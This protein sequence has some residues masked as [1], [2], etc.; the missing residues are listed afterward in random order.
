NLA[1]IMKTDLTTVIKETMYSDNLVYQEEGGRIGIRNGKTGKTSRVP[2]K[3]AELLLAV[4]GYDY[5]YAAGMD[6]NGM[7]TAIYYGK[8][9]QGKDEW[10]KIGLPGP[11][12]AEDI[13]VTANGSVYAVDRRAKII[14][15]LE[16]MD[17]VKYEGELLTVLDDYLVS[18]DGNKLLFRVLK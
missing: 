2:L 7:V 11:A 10:K 15:D 12:K 1:L 17:G 18:V 4:D 8:A 13:F 16:S 5:I 6:E 9:G 14:T 3:E